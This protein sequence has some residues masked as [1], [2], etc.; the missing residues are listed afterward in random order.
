M[1]F[2]PDALDHHHTNSD[3]LSKDYEATCMQNKPCR[4]AKNTN[5]RKRETSKALAQR[6]TWPERAAEASGIS[7]PEV[8]CRAQ[9]QIHVTVM[10]AGSFTEMIGAN[11]VKTL[12]SLLT[13]YWRLPAV[14]KIFK[15]SDNGKENV[16]NVKLLPELGGMWGLLHFVL[17]FPSWVFWY[18]RP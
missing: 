18:M 8:A 12:G 9:G 11:N 2:E 13:P 14:S 10:N 3:F 5:Q 16:W 4:K 1:L 7:H 6:P 17:R 15:G